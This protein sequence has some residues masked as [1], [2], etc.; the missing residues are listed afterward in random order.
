MAGEGSVGSAQIEGIK[1]KQNI[2]DFMEKKCRAEM[3]IKLQHC[4]KENVCNNCG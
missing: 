1:N 2:M 4:F 3:W